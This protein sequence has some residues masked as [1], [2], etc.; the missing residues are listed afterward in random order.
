[1]SEFFFVET[2][3]VADFG[4]LFDPDDRPLVEV[5]PKGRSIESVDVGDAGFSKVD[6]GEAGRFAVEIT[7]DLNCRVILSF[8]IIRPV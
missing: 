7:G 1:L 5:D 3:F 8:S 4:S 2:I 6:V